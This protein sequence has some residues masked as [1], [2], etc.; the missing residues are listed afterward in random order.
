MAARE[1]IELEHEPFGAPFAGSLLL[2]GFVI[3]AVVFLA[4]FGH[5]RGAEWGNNQAARGH[6]SHAGEFGAYDSAAARGSADAQ[7]A[8]Y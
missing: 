6:P 1:T 5:L 2:H 4:F 3:A 7:R 8:G